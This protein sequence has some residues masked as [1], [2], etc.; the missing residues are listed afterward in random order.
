MRCAFAFPL[1]GQADRV[2]VVGRVVRTVL[3]DLSDDGRDVRIPG[4]GVEFERFGGTGDRRALESF[5]HREE[6][7]SLRPES[8]RLSVASA[9]P[10]ASD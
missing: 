2:H 4:I 8:G 9:P 5:L 1:P 7:R 10:A 6:S 3:P